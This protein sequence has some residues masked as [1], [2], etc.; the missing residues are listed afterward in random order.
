MNNQP[1]QLDQALDEIFADRDFEITG[2][3]RHW[4]ST[5]DKKIADKKARAAIKLL[6]LKARKEELRLACENWEKNPTKP[7]SYM[8][9]RTDELK[10]LEEEMKGVTD[11][12]N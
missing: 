5:D 3:P 6:L 7:A 12:K 9:D 10:S 1:D 11:G 8:I 2:I 4:G